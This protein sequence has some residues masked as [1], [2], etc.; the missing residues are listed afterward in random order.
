MNWLTHQLALMPKPGTILHIGAGQCRELPDYQQIEP[1]RIIL[2]EPNPETI[3]ALRQN[4]AEYDNVTLLQAAVAA[5]AGRA[6]L[7]RFNFPELDSLREPTGLYQLLPGLQEIGQTE[8]STISPAQLIRRLS[9]EDSTNNWLVLEAAG[10]E[11]VILEELNRTGALQNFSRLIVRTGAES[12]YK[13]GSCAQPLLELTES[14]GFFV[15]ATPDEEDPDWPRYHLRLDRMA[16]ECKRLKSELD[17]AEQART[18][19]EEQNQARIAELGNALAEQRAKTEQLAGELQSTRD[20]AEQARTRAEELHQARTAELENALAEQRAKAEQ[21]AGELQSTRDKAEQARTTAE[22]QHQTR[23]AELENAKAK[24]IA[25]LNSR[26]EELEKQRDELETARQKL[27]Q[28]EKES[29]AL[30]EKTEAAS[31]LQSQ[32]EQ[33][34][35]T[36]STTESELK[37]TRQKNDDLQQAYRKLEQDY[38]RKEELI[39][40]EFLKAESQIEL[41]KE[42][43]FRDKKV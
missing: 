35:S 40:E 31:K 4:A 21:L 5:E 1:D 24:E 32:L 38:R 43:V 25:A 15:E 12:F 30:A 42:L 28:A 26:I 29:A 33:L 9:L 37:S 27:E 3:N 22:E 10:E 16:L 2:V 39:D 7:H 8:V 19:A 13:G 20:K 41:I 36:L 17:K 23:T 14:L 18:T 6:R 11:A 34:Q